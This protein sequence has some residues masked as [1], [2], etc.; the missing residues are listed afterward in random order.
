MVGIVSVPTNQ[1]EKVLSFRRH[2]VD[3]SEKLPHCWGKISPIIKDEL[4][5]LNRAKSKP[6]KDQAISQV[7][8]SNLTMS[9]NKAHKYL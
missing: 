1:K 2:T 9:P 6:Q 7:F 4:V 5:P 3:Y 8:T